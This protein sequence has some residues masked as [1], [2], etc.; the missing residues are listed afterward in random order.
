MK[1]L[2]Q[3]I[4]HFWEKKFIRFLLIGGINTM[5]GY[6]IFALGIFIGLHYSLATLF[7]IVLGICFN[8]LTTGKIVF[9]NNKNHLIFRFAF[10]YGISYGVNVFFL[11]IFNSLGVNNYLGGAILIFPVAVLSFTLQRFF[12]F[13]E[14][15]EIRRSQKIQHSS[16]IQ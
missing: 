9:N 7:S 14:D 13:S 10:V 6:S 5:F 4:H 15:K 2:Q 1:K 12:V 8:F 16:S 11:Y 3:L